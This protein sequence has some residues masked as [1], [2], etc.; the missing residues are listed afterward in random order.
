MKSGTFEKSVAVFFEKDDREVEVVVDC[1]YDVLNDGIG[2]YE[3]W[4]QKCFDAGSEYIEI[5]NT[6]WDKTGF[7]PVEIAAVEAKIAKLIPVWENEGIDT[8]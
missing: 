6:S 8:E 3:Y 1:E 2:A 5:T 7:S 4:G